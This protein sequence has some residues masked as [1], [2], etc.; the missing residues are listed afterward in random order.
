MDDSGYWYPGY[1]YS[2]NVHPT[3]LGAQVM[4]T[5]VLTDFPELLQYGITDTSGSVEEKYFGNV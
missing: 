5:Q 1:L 4:A 3:E 2:D